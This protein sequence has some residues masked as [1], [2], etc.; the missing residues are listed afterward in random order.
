MAEK[1]PPDVADAVER[2]LPPDMALLFSALR[3]EMHA[4]NDALYNKLLTR[5]LLMG[6]PL[7]AAGG[8][9]A[10]LVKPGVASQTVEAIF[11]VL[12]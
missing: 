9:V 3:S 7:G 2:S 4:R 5:I 8:F 11:R 12:T 1:T 6:I 10:E